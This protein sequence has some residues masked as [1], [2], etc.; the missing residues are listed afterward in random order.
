M[1]INT[2]QRINFNTSSS[3]PNLGKIPSLESLIR[4]QSHSGEDRR[5]R[6]PYKGVAPIFVLRNEKQI[7][8][9]SNLIVYGDSYQEKLNGAKAAIEYER[10]AQIPES[11]ITLKDKNTMNILLRIVNNTIFKDSRE[12]ESLKNIVRA[13]DK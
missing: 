10:L 6:L 12:F 3:I 2:G 1:Y 8:N 9:S 13:N 5:C 11:E 7:E 4:T